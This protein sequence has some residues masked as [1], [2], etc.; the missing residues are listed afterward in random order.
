MVWRSWQYCKVCGLRE[1]AWH[2][3]EG[4][5]Q[6]PA[7]LVL[8]REGVEGGPNACSVEC[9]KSDLPRR[10]HSHEPRPGDHYPGS[11]RSHWQVILTPGAARRGVRQFPAHQAQ[12]HANARSGLRSWVR[13]NTGFARQRARLDTLPPKLPPKAPQRTR[14]PCAAK[15]WPKAGTTAGHP[16][17]PATPE[18]LPGKPNP[19][20]LDAPDCLALHHDGKSEEGII[21]SPAISRRPRTTNCGAATAPLACTR[22]LNCTATATP[23]RRSITSRSWAL[24]MR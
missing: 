1:C 15:G 2:L 21:G 20:E 6:Q 5:L 3:H 16:F 13:I 22:C 17:T 4:T 8:L 18:L 7:T 24:A 9:R 23:P 11:Q 14:K 19:R 10:W 12:P